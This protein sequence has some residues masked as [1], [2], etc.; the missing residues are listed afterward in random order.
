MV[1]F[2]ALIGSTAQ[3]MGAGPDLT[4]P[5]KLRDGTPVE[6]AGIYFAPELTD[7]SERMAF[8]IGEAG[9]QFPER[10]DL[11][12]CPRASIRPGTVAKS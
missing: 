1:K 5:L 2:L 4:A 12:T 8:R 9:G 7:H 10:Y 3:I 11:L 6:S